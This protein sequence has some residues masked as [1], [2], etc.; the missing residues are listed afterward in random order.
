[1]KNRR[2]NEKKTRTKTEPQK[3]VGPHYVPTY[4]QWKSQEEKREK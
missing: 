1:M 4:T 2:K 3:S